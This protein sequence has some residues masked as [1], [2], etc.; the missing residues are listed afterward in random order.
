[1]I[2]WNEQVVKDPSGVVHPAHPPVIDTV[3]LADKTKKYKE[4]TVLKMSAGGETVEAAA[5]TDD[6]VAV[7]TQDSD[8]KNAEALALLHG[9]VVAGRL[10]DA[11]AGTNTKAAKAYYA[12]L[13]AAG[14][15]PL[16]LFD[17]AKVV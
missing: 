9:T 2:A 6:A 17:S 7:L 5:S 11:S 1:M 3:V 16:Q 8:G 12:K 14:I 4:G 13:R 15:Y 10:I